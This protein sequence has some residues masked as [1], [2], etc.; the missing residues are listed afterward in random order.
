MIYLLYLAQTVMPVKKIILLF[1]TLAVL[2]SCKKEKPFVPNYENALPGLWKQL[3]DF[4]GVGRVRAY[5][6]TIGNKAYLI[7]GNAGSGFNVVPL[8]GI[9]PR[10]G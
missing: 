1:I 10:C 9:R 2:A 8:C 3:P 7:G 5:A 6:F 4:P